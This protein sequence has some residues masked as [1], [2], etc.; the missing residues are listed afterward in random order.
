MPTP[1]PAPPDGPAITGQITEMSVEAVVIRANGRREPLGTIAYWHTNP[2]R[3]LAWRL[4]HKRMQ[5]LK[6]SNHG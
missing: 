6:E 3:R 1:P 4:T 5:Q 2:L